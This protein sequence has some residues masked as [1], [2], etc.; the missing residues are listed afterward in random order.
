ML[1]P[2]LIPCLL[3]KNGSLVKTVKFKEETYV[4]DPL[5]AV[6]IYNEKKVDEIIVLDINSSLE[7]LPL[8]LNLI[9][10]IAKEC[11]IPLCYGGG[12]NS[13]DQIESLISLG[14]EKIALGAAAYQQ[15]ELV[16]Q[17]AKRLGKQSI[18]GVVDFKRFGLRQSPEVVINKAKKKVGLS[19]TQAALNLEKL[20]VGEILLQSVDRDGV[21]NG[22]DL[23]TIKSV[24]NSIKIPLTVLGGAGSLENVK[25][26]Y[27]K[28][29]LI[30]CAA[31]SIFTFKGR[32]RAVLINYPDQEQKFSL[33]N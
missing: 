32:F 7:K 22:Y 14:V 26:V 21:C 25:D 6:R 8:N 13:I 3:I 28:F 18:V 9:S 27:N 23:D 30:G 2:R 29:G 19:P 16:V 12:I 5:N 4:G 11:R 20:G 33:Y 17:A 24:R 10:K 15:P 1:N 31:G